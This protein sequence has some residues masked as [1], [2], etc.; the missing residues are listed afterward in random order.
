MYYVLVIRKLQHNALSVPWYALNLRSFY[1]LELENL[2]GDDEAD[3]CMPSRTAG[4]P[5]WIVPSLEWLLL[6]AFSRQK[7]NCLTCNNARKHHE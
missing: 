1:L 3:S 2:E 6:L 4:H 7:L 5:E